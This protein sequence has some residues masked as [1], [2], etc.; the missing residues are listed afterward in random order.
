MGSEMLRFA[1]HDRAVTQTNAWITVF[2]CIIG[3]YSCPDYFVKL[4]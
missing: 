3:P 2:M 4:A 1:Q